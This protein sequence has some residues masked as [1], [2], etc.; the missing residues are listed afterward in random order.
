MDDLKASLLTYMVNLVVILVVENK[1]NCCIPRSLPRRGCAAV[2]MLPELRNCK[3][4]INRY[5]VYNFCACP[6]HQV[7]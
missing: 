6:P 5:S 2:T 1:R 7:D 4:C 3:N